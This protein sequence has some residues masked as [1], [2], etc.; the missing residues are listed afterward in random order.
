[1]LKRLILAILTVIAITFIGT[2]LISSVTEPQ[3]QSRLQLYQIDLVLNAAEWEGSNQTL[4][5]DLTLAQKALFGEDIYQTAINQY[6]DV[7]HL[8]ETSLTQLKGNQGD[9]T[10]PPPVALIQEQQAL[11]DEL[12]LRLGILEVQ[13]N[14][15]EQGLKTWQNLIDY[16]NVS[17]RSVINT[18]QVLINL[19]NS[20]TEL[21]PDAEITLQQNLKGWFRY[22]ALTQLYTVQ[23]RQSELAT[24][25]T[26]EQI[27]A[28]QSVVKL[29]IIN[30]I[31]GLG[32]VIGTGLLIFTG[33]QWLIKRQDS[34]LAQNAD[35]TWETPWNGETILQVFVVG[36]FLVGQLVVP[37]FLSIVKQ[38][39]PLGAVI[40]GARGQ[41][42][43]ILASYLT[44]TSGTLAVLY[45]SLKSF[46]PLPSGWFNFKWRQNWLGWG[47]GGYCV[48][49]PLVVL[50]S[51][52]N[53]KIWQGQGGSNPIL[54][55]A[56]ESQDWVALSVFFITAS[57]AAPMFEEIMFRGFLLPSLTRYV[58]LWGAISLSALLFAIAHQNASEILPLFVLG[59][60][61]G[62]VYSRSRN[63]LSS[64]L[65]HS[66]WNSGTL[67]SLYILGG[68]AG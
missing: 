29:S 15:L 13:E 68:G 67:L 49:L 8:A 42:I 27:D 52:L 10:Q 59:C 31:P 19:W 3:V 36:F 32:F 53:Q 56:L 37:V 23:E 24:L 60:V 6:Q 35:V 33:I 18:A 43:F 38:I 50:V 66:L 45:F 39:T 34:L 30:A 58:P 40:T 64:M 28:Q 21:S 46:L 5:T 65:L 16:P 20:S 2:A 1:M 48:A 14:N 61:L 17:S 26:Q 25:N 57:I 22:R 12:D 62:F 11:I 54:S 7:R 44:L 41:A 47:F 63:L 4:E 51:L 9:P 55:I